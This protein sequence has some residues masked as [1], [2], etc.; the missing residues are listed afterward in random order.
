MLDHL[1]ANFD[2]FRSYQKRV[3]LEV[4][5]NILNY[6]A[7]SL[8]SLEKKE[9]IKCVG[10]FIDS[11]WSRTHTFH[12]FHIRLASL[13]AFYQ[14]W[15][16]LSHKLCCL[17][18]I[19]LL[20]KLTCPTGLQSEAKLLNRILKRCWLCKNVLILYLL[21]TCQ[22]FFLFIRPISKRSVLLC[23]ILSTI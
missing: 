23:M 8:D 20:F 3:N 17:T 10:V 6:S 5:I 13:W 16:I 22:T 12:L 19:D 21:S 18:Y 9:Y 11:T 2:L 7:N 14:D 15:E 1:N 4:N